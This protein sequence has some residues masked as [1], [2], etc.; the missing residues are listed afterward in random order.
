MPRLYMD[1]VLKRNSKSYRTFLRDLAGRGLLG[2]TT[3]PAESVGLFFVAKSNGAQRMIIDA[4]R[5]NGHFRT[6]P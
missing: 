4:R 1:P 6:P 5:S 2:V 3:R